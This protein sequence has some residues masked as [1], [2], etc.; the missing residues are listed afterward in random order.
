[1][2]AND[3]SGP[4]LMRTL[5][6]LSNELSHFLLPPPGFA[7]AGSWLERTPVAGAAHAENVQEPDDH[8]FDDLAEPGDLIAATQE[9]DSAQIG[10]SLLA[11]ITP[12]GTD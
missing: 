3:P 9:Y 1:V 8:E 7:G 10:M 4:L 2:A 5:W 12:A 11:G 6:Q